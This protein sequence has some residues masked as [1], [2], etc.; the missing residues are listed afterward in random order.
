VDLLASLFVGKPQN[1][2]V[3]AVVFLTGYLALGFTAFGTARHSRPLFIASITW[4][5][6][7]A[8]ESLVQTKTPEANIRVDLLV[9]G[10]LLGILSAW[11]VFRAFP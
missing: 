9:I 6:Y 11:A 5:L 3:V 10:P 1:I 4:G 7:G 2:L 8:W